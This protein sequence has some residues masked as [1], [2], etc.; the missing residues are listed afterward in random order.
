MVQHAIGDPE[1][2]SDLRDT[3][4]AGLPQPDRFHAALVGREHSLE[5]TLATVFQNISPDGT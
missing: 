5:E 2:A 3:L 4:A 1:I